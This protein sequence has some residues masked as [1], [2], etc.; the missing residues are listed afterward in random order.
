MRDSVKTTIR[1]TVQDLA[2]IGL[3]TTFTQRE[4]TELGVE[5][6]EISASPSQIREV[7]KSLR[8][9]QSV[10][11]QL[12]N[13]SVASVRHWESGIRK[14]SGSTIVLLDLLRK[15]PKALN[16]RMKSVSGKATT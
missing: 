11:A 15:K 4:L 13:V 8:V 3:P 10:F 2:D 6:P 5:I 9:S 12:L 7:R 14:P 1:D 16:Y